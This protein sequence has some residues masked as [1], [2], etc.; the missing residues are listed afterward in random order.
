[1]KSDNLVRGRVRY[2]AD[3]APADAQPPR[4]A[5]HEQ[6]LRAIAAHRVGDRPDRFE[7]RKAKR[8]PE[9]YDRLTRPRRDIKIQM[10]KRDRKM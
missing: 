4:A 8:R 2:S 7:P 10:L 3:S 5:L 6:A 1:V 9:K